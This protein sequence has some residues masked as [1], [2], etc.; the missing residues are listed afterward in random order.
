[1]RAAWRDYTPYLRLYRSLKLSR[2]TDALCDVL[3][4]LIHAAAMDREQ[5]TKTAIMAA[6]TGDLGVTCTLMDAHRTG[7][8]LYDLPDVTASRSG[9]LA[10]RASEALRHYARMAKS[11]GGFVTLIAEQLTGDAEDDYHS[12]TQLFAS[13]PGSSP[14]KARAIARMLAG[15][16]AWDWN[17]DGR[18]ALGTSLP[19]I[20]HAGLSLI[21]P[22]QPAQDAADLFTLL[23]ADTADS[24]G[25]PIGEGLDPH[26]VAET[27][28]S[29]QRLSVATYYVGL[30]IDQMQADLIRAP[31][32]PLTTQA[33][34]SRAAV[35]PHR[36]LGEKN[37]WYGP[38]P[39]R[40]TVFR[41][42][43][44]IAVRRAPA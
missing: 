24:L 19:S 43:G 31:H 14:R 2:D 33:W 44:H 18:G 6:L 4:H 28:A 40:K 30:R 15:C 3:T 25:H 29:L 13:A 41:D 36:Y 5:A 11:A 35:L 42:T 37:G 21:A 39:G 17:C 23:V 32:T 9:P 10:E 34:A 8:P 12:A 22:A 38:T 1:M 7:T 26:G 27:L 16:A 20:A